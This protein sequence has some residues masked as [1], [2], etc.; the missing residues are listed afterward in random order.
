MAVELDMYSEEKIKLEVA[1]PQG[2]AEN[3][4]T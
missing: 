2:A 4:L 3:I 1:W